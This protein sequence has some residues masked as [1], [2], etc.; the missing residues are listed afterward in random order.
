MRSALL[1]SFAYPP[2]TPF[3]RLLPREPR[4]GVEGHLR[5]AAALKAV[6]TPSMNCIDVGAY[7][8]DMLRLI[9]QCAPHGT[10]F[11]WEPLPYMALRLKR[12]FPTV[13]VQAAALSDR[14]GEA[15][16]TH[17]RSRPTYSGILPRK[18]PGGETLETITVPVQRLDTAL[19]QGYVPDL[20]KIDVEGAELR[21]LRGA[22]DILRRHRPFVFFEHGRGGADFYGTTANDIFEFLTG[23][24]GLTISDIDGTRS[25]S[26]E[27]FVAVDDRSDFLAHR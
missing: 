11:A 2:L 3:T 25:Y 15:T 22:A 23:E 10:H 24:C 13:H 8:G 5:L 1:R 4:Q 26:R 20:L 12:R 27:L 21:V 7:A 6:L 14:E 18:Y 19:P 9:V 17:V 16:F